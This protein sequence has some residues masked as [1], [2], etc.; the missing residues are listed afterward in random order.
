MK[1]KS[2][3]YSTLTLLPHPSRGIQHGSYYQGSRHRRHRL[4]RFSNCK[5][6]RTPVVFAVTTSAI[7]PPCSTAA[8]RSQISQQQLKFWLKKTYFDDDTL[9]ER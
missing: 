6:A 8:Q 3:F 4:G 1:K 9:L 7:P 2:G 5:G